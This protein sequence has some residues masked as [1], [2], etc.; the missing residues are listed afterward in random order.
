MLLYSN[1][2]MCEFMS[3]C[4][5]CLDPTLVDAAEDGDALAQFAV[6]V[7]FWKGNGVPKDI[8]IAKSWWQRAALKWVCGCP[9][10]SW[11]QVFE[12]AGNRRSSVVDSKC[13]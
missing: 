9:I 12:A 5:E 3:E 4:I 6:G 11:V 7:I 2:K 8:E 1:F 10:L 13:G